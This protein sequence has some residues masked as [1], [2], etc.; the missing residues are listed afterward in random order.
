[1]RIIVN[2]DLMN[3]ISEAKQGYS[4]QRCFK[5]A[6]LITALGEVIAAVSNAPLSDMAVS[7]PFGL[8]ILY[9]VNKYGSYALD[10]MD[11][12]LDDLDYLSAD[13][14]EI[15]VMTNRDLILES[16]TYKTEYKFQ[17]DKHKL[18]YIL[19]KKYINVPTTKKNHEV[20]LLQEHILGNREYFI[21]K[22]NAYDEKR[23]IRRPSWA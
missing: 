10:E 22:G 2:Y 12:A 20:S 1:M 3:R 16:E 11:D 21:S 15:H 17:L 4:V 8:L 19:E 5:N 7:M 14:E 13:L 9:L 23:L 6:V 18:P